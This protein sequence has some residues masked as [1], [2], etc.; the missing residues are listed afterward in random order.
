MG[1]MKFELM[2]NQQQASAL[3]KAMD[4][5]KG[6]VQTFLLNFV[7]GNSHRQIVIRDTKLSMIDA[8]HIDEEN[9]FKKLTCN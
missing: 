7:I 1:I 5:L 9:D 6:N 4:K 3:L 2:T 8:F